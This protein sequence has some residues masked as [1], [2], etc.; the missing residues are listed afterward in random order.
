MGIEI[1]YVEFYHKFILHFLSQVFD[2]SNYNST[3]HR[4]PGMHGQKITSRIWK[5]GF[6]TYG[7]AVDPF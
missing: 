3:R 7:G 6:S 5:I 1:N 2:Y 4:K